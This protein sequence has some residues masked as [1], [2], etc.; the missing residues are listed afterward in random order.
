MCN[1]RRKKKENTIFTFKF[2]KLEN[3]YKKKKRSLMYMKGYSE[4]ISPIHFPNIRI[5]L[6]CAEKFSA[7]TRVCIYLGGGGRKKTGTPDPPF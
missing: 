1:K 5:F 3:F 7:P 4:V 2:L 6:G